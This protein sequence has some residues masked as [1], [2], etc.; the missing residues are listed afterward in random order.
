MNSTTA[1]VEFDVVDADHA[2][3]STIKRQGSYA[4]HISAPGSAANN[5]TFFA[6]SDSQ[7]SYFFRFYVYV[8]AAPAA[9]ML[10][11]SVQNSSSANKIS[12]R[13]N[14]DRTLQL[15]NSED[16]AQIGS[17]SSALALNTWYRVEF[18]VDTT[19]LAT[20]VCAARIDGSQFASGNANLATGISRFSVGP[21]AADA[22]MDVYYDDLAINDTTGGAQTSYP[23][24]GSVIRLKPNAA[25]DVNTFG[26]QTGGTAG[27]GNN[28]TRV[29]EVT[30]DNST[31]FNG[32]STLNQEDLFNLDASGLQSYD[33]VTLVEVWMGFRN[34]TADATTAIKA[35]IEKTASGTITQS[36]AL[37]PNSTS[38]SFNGI[39]ALIRTP[40]PIVAYTDP[41]GAAWTNTTLDS[42]QVGYKLTLLGVNR[43]DVTSVS[44]MV[45]YVPG[46]PTSNPANMLLMRAA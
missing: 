15:Y 6:A 28:Y 33:T 8:V 16:T 9:V 27:S 34:N 26:S 38:W 7:A 14:T 46:T 13:I 5:R 10:L 22:S 4:A 35:E 29:N 32:S 12:I 31:S 36:A 40:A 25:G 2:I 3:Q 37:V 1:A 43:I 18:A 23:G 45:E 24:A 41:D 20:T 19:T 30:A 11:A 44:A 42:M 39:P 17:N 21:V